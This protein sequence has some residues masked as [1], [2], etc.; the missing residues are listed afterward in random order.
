LPLS[1]VPTIGPSSRIV[2]KRTNEKFNYKL[3]LVPNDRGMVKTVRGKRRHKTPLIF[4]SRNLRS[5]TR[6]QASDDAANQL[7]GSTNSI[8][9]TL[10]R[11]SAPSVTM[12][13]IIA[14]SSAA[15]TTASSVGLMTTSVPSGVTTTTTTTNKGSIMSAGIP[16]R[17]RF[18]SFSSSKGQTKRS[19]KERQK[20]K[21]KFARKRRETRKSRSRSSNEPFE[22]E[23]SSDSSLDPANLNSPLNPVSPRRISE[24][25]KKRA[26]ESYNESDDNSE[27]EERPLPRRKRRKTDLENEEDEAEK[28]IRQRKE[29]LQIRGQIAKLILRVKDMVIHVDGLEYHDEADPTSFLVGIQALFY[30]IRQKLPLLLTQYNNYIGIYPEFSQ[31]HSDEVVSLVQVM[32]EIISAKIGELYQIWSCTRPYIGQIMDI[33]MS[34]PRK[35]DHSVSDQGRPVS[36]SQAHVRDLTAEFN[37]I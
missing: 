27:P 34:L 2:G 31:Q 1:L 25:A 5:N 28:L 17:S 8:S 20:A 35:T 26:R 24:N 11:S 12:T 21:K 22:D 10:A 6:R 9:A 33:D 19:R 36:G 29:A 15:V 30:E 4:F 37:Q 16:L 23:E 3:V 14:S 13:T 32:D 7:I 18:S